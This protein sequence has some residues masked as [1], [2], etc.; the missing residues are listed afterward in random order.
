MEFFYCTLI[1]VPDPGLEPGS[2]AKGVGF[3]YHFGFRRHLCSWS[4]LYLHHNL[5]G[6]RCLPSSL[7]TFRNSFCFSLARY[8]HFTAFTDFD[9]FYSSCF[10]EGTQIRQVRYVYQFRQSGIAVLSTIQ[11]YSITLAKIIFGWKVL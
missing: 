8:W 11:V 2:P 1:L 5:L 4:G 7:Y 9:R 6:R 3:S 10:Q